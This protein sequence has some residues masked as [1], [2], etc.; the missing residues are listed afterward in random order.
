VTLEAD[1]DELAPDVADTIPELFW[2]L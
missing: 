1:G 2:L